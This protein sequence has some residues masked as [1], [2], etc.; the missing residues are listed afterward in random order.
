LPRIDWI[1][2][3]RAGQLTNL[4]WKELTKSYYFATSKLKKGKYVMMTLMANRR[5]RPKV[6][7]SKMEKSRKE[8]QKMMKMINKLLMSS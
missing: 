4:S 2:L 5:K 7:N 1:L 3:A 8:T 6:K